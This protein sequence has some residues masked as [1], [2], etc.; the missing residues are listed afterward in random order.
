MPTNTYLTGWVGEI[1]GFY[2]ALTDKETS[3]IQIFNEEVDLA[4]YNR[5]LMMTGN[6][7][8]YH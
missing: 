3:N 4:F 2:M 7:Q 1:I 6:R 8:N 5:R